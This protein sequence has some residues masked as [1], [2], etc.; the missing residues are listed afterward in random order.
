[1]WIGFVSTYEMFESVGTSSIHL[2]FIED[3]QTSIHFAVLHY[4]TDES[5]EIIIGGGNQSNGQG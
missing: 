1:M 5:N 2:F 3:R 4:V